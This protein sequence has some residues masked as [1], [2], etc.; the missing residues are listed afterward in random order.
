MFKTER[1]TYQFKWQD[2]GD[3]EKGRPNL[4][5]LMNVAVYRLMQYTLRDVLINFPRVASLEV[6]R[7]YQPETPTAKK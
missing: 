5:N 6:N 1:E 3:I 7:L 2:I 4:G